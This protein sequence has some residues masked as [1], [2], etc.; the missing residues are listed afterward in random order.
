M[1]TYQPGMTIIGRFDL[2]ERLG[3]GAM[4]IVYGAVDKKLKEEVALK[5]LPSAMAEDR[6]AV[7][8]FAGEVRRARRVSG[9]YILRVYDMWEDGEG[10]HFVTMECAKGG[11]LKARQLSRGLLSWDETKLLL[12]PILKGLQSVHDAGIIHRD[13]KPGNILF[14]KDDTPV[15]ADFGISKTIMASMSRITHDSTISGT[16]AYMAPEAIQGNADICFGTD[17]YAVGCLAYELLLGHPPFSGD[18]MSVMYN[19]MHSDPSFEGI[20]GAAARWIGACLTKDVTHRVQTSENLIRCLDN[21]WDLPEYIPVRQSS[22]DSSVSAEINGAYGVGEHA[23]RTR[24]IDT[25]PV[26][27]PDGRLPDHPGFFRRSLHA[28]AHSHAFPWVLGAALVILIILAI[29]ERFPAGDASQVVSIQESMPNSRL[30]NRSGESGVLRDS[31]ETAF[32]G[33]AGDDDAVDRPAIANLEERAQQL[34]LELKFTSGDNGSAWDVCK[35]ILDMDPGNAVSLQLIARMKE[36][37]ENWIETSLGSGDC[38][39]ATAYAAALTQIGSDRTYQKEIAGCLERK[40]GSSAAEGICPFCGHLTVAGNF[41]TSC[42][43]SL[44]DLTVVCPACN[45]WTADEKFCIHCR[46]RLK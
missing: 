17:L 27:A 45:T 30:G 42:G 32:N 33:G 21:P 6:E 43:E 25:P 44:N 11:D 31:I 15:V 28:L 36:Q 46:Q 22:G 35:Q 19:Q 41:C 7:Q 29:R 5:F 20:P 14:R 9:R 23:I 2:V 8:Q 1:N 3:A 4:G 10:G 18:V 12:L 37:Y 26:S 34:F 39:K 13:V 24:K 16:P 38:S 40:Q